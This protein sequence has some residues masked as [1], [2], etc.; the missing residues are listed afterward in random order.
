MDI[1]LSQINELSRPFYADT[2]YNYPDPKL[3]TLYGDLGPFWYRGYYKGAK[4]ASIQQI[5]FTLE[6]FNVKKI[7]TGHT[8]IA[9][10]IS[11]LHNGKLINTDVHHAKG[12]SEA[13]LIEGDRYYRITI[14]GEKFQLM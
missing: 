11:V 2:T 1:T 4:L 6:K 13:L 3:D 14:K 9:D 10:T 8:M 12:H 7:A 5:D